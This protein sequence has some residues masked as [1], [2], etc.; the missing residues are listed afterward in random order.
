MTFK[1][2]K[3]LGYSIYDRKLEQCYVTRKPR[4]DTQVSVLTAKGNRAG[5]LYILMPNHDSTRYSWRCYLR[6]ENK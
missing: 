3:E 6:K 1:E 4:T 5:E 2:A